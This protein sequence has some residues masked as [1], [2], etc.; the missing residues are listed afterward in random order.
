MT[1]LND[2]AKSIVVSPIIGKDVLDDTTMS[3]NE[4]YNLELISK[5]QQYYKKNLI[6]RHK[7]VPSLYLLYQNLLSENTS[8]AVFP[9]F[10]LTI[11]VSMLCSLH[12]FITRDESSSFEFVRRI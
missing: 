1:F 12:L 2:F 3:K 9:L 11:C 8:S 6:F 10:F 7:N 4:H 5:V